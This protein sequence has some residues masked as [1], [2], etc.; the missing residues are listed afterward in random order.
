MADPIAVREPMQAAAIERGLLGTILVAREGINGT[1]AGPRSGIESL[2]AWLGRLPGLA[3]LRGHWSESM[4]APFQ[5]MRVRVRDEIVTLGRPDINPAEKTGQ[6]VDAATWNQLLARDDVV[7]IDTRN[8]YEVE[9]GTFPGIEHPAT[10]SFRE[11]PAYVAAN[12]E[13]FAGK[14]VAMFCTGGIR[15]EK[16]AALLIREGIDEVYQLDGGILTYLET[17]RPDEN[18]W[19]GECFVFDT[20][21]AVDR[22][23][24]PGDYLQC[25]AC[26]RPLGP[27][28]LASPLYEEGL[29]C[30]YCH[31]TIEPERMARLRERRRQN[32][33]RRQRESERQ[34]KESA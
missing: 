15:C 21:V 33:L 4:E 7:V 12:R 1:V 29:S 18:R 9:V 3:A 5:K 30:P 8:D 23:L 14:P 31:G 2:L 24:A 10:A 22:D 11:F 27:A 13:R 16:A 19:Q 28:E 25:H 32:D 6:Y 17:V 20:R 26:R 34:R